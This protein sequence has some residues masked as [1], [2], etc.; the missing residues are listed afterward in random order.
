M[1]LEQAIALHQQGKLAE[2]EPLYRHVLAREPGRFEPHYYLGVLCMPLG[3]FA[4]AVAFLQEL[5]ASAVPYRFEV[6]LQPE[7]VVAAGK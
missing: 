6:R 3:R 7:P 1:S 5:L 2:A 4:E